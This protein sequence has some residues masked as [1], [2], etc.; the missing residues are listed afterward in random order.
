MVVA[1]F[2][3]TLAVFFA[4]DF[5]LRREDR[6]MEKKDK[7]KKSPIFLSP[8]KALIPLI[9]GKERLFHLSHSWVQK[10]DEE[11]VY[12]GYDNFIPFLFSSKIKIN[13]LPLIGSEDLNAA[14]HRRQGQ[15]IGPRRFYN[16]AERK[17]DLY[18]GG[19]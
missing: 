10:S 8:D 9:N 15:S 11:Y 7:A 3:L 1:L 17:G 14:V 4:V 5:F 18:Q 16:L 6:V 2:I 19:C 12:V 13:E